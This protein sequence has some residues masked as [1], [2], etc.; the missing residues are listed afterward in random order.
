[1]FSETDFNFENNLPYD[2]SYLF[3][4]EFEV[5]NSSASFSQDTNPISHNLSVSSGKLLTKKRKSS[6]RSVDK[7]AKVKNQQLRADELLQA[8]KQKLWQPD[9]TAE[10][11]KKIRNQIAAQESR[12]K[13][14][15]EIDVLKEIVADLKAEIAVLKQKNERILCSKCSRGLE[16][17]VSVSSLSSSSRALKMGIGSVLLMVMLVLCVSFQSKTPFTS[18][19]APRRLLTEKSSS[20]RLYE[21]LPKPETPKELF[22]YLNN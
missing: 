8:R 20:L 15:E 14:R 1:M 18:Q 3:E 4:E 12:N 5:H 11:R 19:N 9:L 13:K 10:E 2:H 16:E 21:N 17:E 6:Y 7:V 22:R